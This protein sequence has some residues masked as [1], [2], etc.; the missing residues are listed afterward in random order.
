M[1]LDVVSLILRAASQYLDFVCVCVYVYVCMY[2]Y[3]IF[4][5]TSSDK[6][7]FHEWYWS[8]SMLYITLSKVP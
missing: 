4:Y 6:L 5:Q 8:I 3:Y 1:C 7:L 2:V